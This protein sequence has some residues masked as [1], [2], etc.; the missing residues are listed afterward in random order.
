METIIKELALDGYYNENVR[1][2]LS[3][4][5]GLGLKICNRLARGLNG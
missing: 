3:C 1:E 5:I 2:S 4:D